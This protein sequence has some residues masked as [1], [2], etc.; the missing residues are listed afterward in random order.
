MLAEECIGDFCEFISLD[1]MKLAELT[2]GHNVSKYFKKDV[3]AGSK[4]LSVFFRNLS[5]FLKQED[6][7]LKSHIIW[8]KDA[9]KILKKS[10]I[11]SNTTESFLVTTYISFTS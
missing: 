9:N 10:K 3:F 2:S 5:T 8:S 7:R 4:Y 11:S 1:S 6:Y